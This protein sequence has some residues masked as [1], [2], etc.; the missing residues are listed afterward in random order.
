M[1]GWAEFRGLYRSA[2]ML[3]IEITRRLGL[4]RDTEDNAAVQPEFPPRYERAPVA[5]SAWLDEEPD[6]AGVVCGSVRRWRP[7]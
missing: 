4:L 5:S 7:R 2:K 3:Q 6:G 1:K